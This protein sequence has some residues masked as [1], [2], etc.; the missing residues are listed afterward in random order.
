[1]KKN[2]VQFKGGQIMKTR[3]LLSA[4]AALAIAAPALAQSGGLRYTITVTKFENHSQYHTQYDLGSA[5]GAVMTDRLNRTGRFIALG[6]TDM[7]NEAM[8]E[9]D[10][11]RSGRT[12][13][14]SKTPV[15]GQ[16]SPA[17]LLV[18]GAITHI[19]H[20]TSGGS[21]GFSIKGIGLGGKKSTMEV[22]ATIYVVDSTTG[23]VVAST[24]VVGKAKAKGAKVSYANYGTAADLEGFK[25]DNLGRAVEKAVDEAVGWI[26][27]QLPNIRWRGSVAF[28]KDGRVYINRGSREGITQGQ[29]FLVGDAEVIRDPDTGEVLDELM[30]EVAHLRVVSIKDK[31]SICEVSQGDPTDIQRGMAV[32]LP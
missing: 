18:K 21:G 5:W 20:D 10:F 27:E 9:Q 13:Q 15:T 30:I 17:Q 25:K 31:L 7:R 19:E 23:Q 1:M 4:L 16:M 14:G 2:L 12:V 32:H 26:L 28:V 11:A 8:G 29:S 24:S 6:E 22:N 3:F